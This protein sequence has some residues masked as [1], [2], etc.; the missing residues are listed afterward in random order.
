MH[1]NLLTLMSLD[2]SSLEQIE[3]YN[4]AHERI[5]GEN[6]IIPECEIKWMAPTQGWYKANWDVAIDKSQGR[7]GIG[8]IIRDEK[9]QTI[10]AMS[11]TRLKN[12]E[13]TMEEAF[14]A[15]NAACLCRDLKLQHIMM[16]GDAKL[17]VDAVN[18]NSSTWSRFGH[19]ID[20]TQQILD[21]F[22]R[23]KCNHVRCEANGVVHQL[24]KAATTDV[25]DRI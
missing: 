10:A 24:V 21:D 3:V 4:R 18:S 25:N 9:G 6:E 13:P 8:V 1:Q 16:E 14:A 23:W 5:L 15:F 19:I 20:H 22:I 17:I 11:K 2:R 12:L 7:V